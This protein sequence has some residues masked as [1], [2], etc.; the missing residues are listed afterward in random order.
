M[1][2][3]LSQKQFDAAV[4]AYNAKQKHRNR[5]I[6]DYYHKV[7]NSKNQ[8]TQHEFVVQVGSLPKRLRA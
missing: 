6:T 4:E 7:K 2:S 3:K 1:T 8:Q 5:R